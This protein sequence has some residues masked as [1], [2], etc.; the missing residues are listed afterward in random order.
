MKKIFSIFLLIFLTPFF[1]FA[2]PF[3][4]L[5]GQASVVWSYKKVKLRFD[6]LIVVNNLK[7]ATFETLN[8]FGGTVMKF[9]F[10][11]DGITM[12]DQGVDAGQVSDKQFKKMMFLPLGREE[13]ISYVLNTIPAN[14]KDLTIT[15][16]KTD[17]TQIEKVVKKTKNKK[18]NYTVFFSDY[19]QVGEKWFPYKMEIKSG[20]TGFLMVWKDVT[21]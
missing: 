21:E 2:T 16:S 17:K 9:Y 12:V 4:S 20:K 14:A 8:D 10:S 5:K 1:A 15:Y 18:T 7:E 13:F 11:E 19:R 3:T 6:E